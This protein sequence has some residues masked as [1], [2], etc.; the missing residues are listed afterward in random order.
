[1]ITVKNLCKSFNGV[2]V[3]D[4]VSTRIEKGEKGK[5]NASTLCTRG[6][7]VTY[8]YRFLERKSLLK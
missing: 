4:N 6:S 8:L 7:T 5:F 2:K 3:L 1:M